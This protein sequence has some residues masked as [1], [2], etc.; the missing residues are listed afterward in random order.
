MRKKELVAKVNKAENKLIAMEYTMHVMQSQLNSLFAEN[1]L[2]K[3]PNGLFGNY[4]SG[5][6]RHTTYR[7]AVRLTKNG[8]LYLTEDA[9]EDKMREDV[10]MFSNEDKTIFLAKT[11][12]E[13]E[14]IYLRAISCDS[15]RGKLI[16]V[17]EPREKVDWKPLNKEAYVY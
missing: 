15:N 7:I 13:E 11:D 6:T 16:E 12:M 4:A 9:Y 2:L 14:D 5:S 3:N 8:L 10:V 17:A 1:W